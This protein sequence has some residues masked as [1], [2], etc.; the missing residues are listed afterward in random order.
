[1]ILNI[2]FIPLFG[3]TGAAYTKLLSG[4]IYLLPMYWFYRR[5]IVKANERKSED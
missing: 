2:I 4:L 5:L 3:E 1:L